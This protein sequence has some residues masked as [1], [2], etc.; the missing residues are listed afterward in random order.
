VEVGQD[1][2]GVSRSLPTRAISTTMREEGGSAH[3][4]LRKGNFGGN[5]HVEEIQA[6][7]IK[8]IFT[9]TSISLPQSIDTETIYVATHYVGR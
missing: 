8:L 2:S 9:S 4:S 3:G 7:G 6:L 1:D 5:S